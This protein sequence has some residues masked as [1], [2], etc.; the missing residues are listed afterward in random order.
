MNRRQLM[1]IS[2]AA[3]VAVHSNDTAA[4]NQATALIGSSDAQRVS[5]A[6]GAHAPLYQMLTSD[7]QAKLTALQ[8]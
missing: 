8:S 2:G 3:L 5:A 6:A 7:Q 4:I 1:L